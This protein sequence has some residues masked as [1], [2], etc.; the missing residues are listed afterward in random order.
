MDDNI[1]RFY[2]LNN[3]WK[4]PV[5]DGTIFKIAEDF[6][7]RYKNV[8]ISGLNYHS[9]CPANQK[10]PPFLA[11]TRIYSCLFIR[12]DIPYRWRGRY[13]EDTDL[14]LRVLKDGWCTI[15]FNAFLQGKL[16]TTS[17]AK[18]QKGGNTEQFYSKEGTYNKTKML[19]DMHPDVVR[20]VWKFG[21]CHHHV[22]YRPFKKNRLLKKPNLKIPNKVNNYGMKLTKLKVNAFE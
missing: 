10:Y 21:R 13:N 15:Q 4:L 16:P 6:V 8:A 18:E 9:F 12:N 20:M 19:Y 3:N 1:R 17:V 7:L 5:A 22:D 11:N 14:S 2:R